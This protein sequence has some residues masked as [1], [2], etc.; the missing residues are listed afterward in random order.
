MKKSKWKPDS[1]ETKK[2]NYGESLVDAIL[3]K[4]GH[5]YKPMPNGGHPIDSIVLSWET[6]TIT[7]FYDTK[8]K[9]TKVMYKRTGYDKKHHK[10]YMAIAQA[11]PDIE[12]NVYFVDAHPDY[13][14]I[15]KGD[16]RKLNDDRQEDTKSGIFTFHISIL[17]KVRDLTDEEVHAINNEDEQNASNQRFYDKKII[18][19]GKEPNDNEYPWTLNDTKYPIQTDDRVGEVFVTI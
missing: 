15:W 2:G 14:C 5:V 11:N 3:T 1:V 4:K 16:V 13:K 9:W 10:R 7:E 19:E 18:G 6:S 8:A 17:E 12:V